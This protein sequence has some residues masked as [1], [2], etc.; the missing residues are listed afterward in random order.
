VDNHIGAFLIFGGIAGF[1][2]IL[3]NPPKIQAKIIRNIIETRAIFENLFIHSFTLDI[4]FW[5]AT[6]SRN[7]A[8][9]D[10]EI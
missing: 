10:L 4:D 1:C 8:R 6:I 3:G 7:F 2:Q 9:T 5:F